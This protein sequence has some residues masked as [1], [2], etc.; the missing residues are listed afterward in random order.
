M[1]SRDDDTISKKDIFNM[2]DS[3]KSNVEF[4][5]ELLESQSKILEQHND[6]ITNLNKINEKQNT[7]NINQADIGNH[8][9]ILIDKLTCHN[10]NCSSNK[11]EAVTSVK[12]GIN[13]INSHHLESI[14]SHSVLR[15]SIIAGVGTLSSIV[16]SLIYI[17]YQL[18]SK[19]DKLEAIS[20]HLG[21]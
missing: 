13:K 8:L 18:V 4:N 14:K 5:K 17:I 15:N 19:I 9:E 20:K 3:Y 2:M 21:V 1:N 16:V 10:T 12:E 7:N 11:D 6:I